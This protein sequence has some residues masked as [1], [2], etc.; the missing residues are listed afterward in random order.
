MRSR[1]RV[2]TFARC[3]LFVLAAAFCSV[4]CFASQPVQRSIAVDGMTRSYV[5][6]IPDGP[7][8]P[9]PVV[10][11]FHGGGGTVEALQNNSSLHEARDARN[12]LI[13]YPVGYR[14][15]FNV[16]G[17]CCGP[18]A[19]QN[20]D[21][22]GF[23]RALLADLSSVAPIDRRRIYSVG[24]SNGGQFS[25]YLACHMSEQ[26]AAIASVAGSM[27]P[28]FDTCRPSRPVPI[29]QWSG[30]A[31]RFDPFEGGRSAI[32]SAPLQPPVMQGIELWR[33][34][35]GTRVT[36]P[37]DVV[38]PGANCTESSGGPGNAAVVLCLVPGL[39][40]QWPG[41]N[42]GPSARMLPQLGPL[43]PALDVNDAIL[44]FFSRYSLP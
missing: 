6:W 28:P 11:A 40:H 31:D 19:R 22:L 42:Q 24:F 8:R 33:R 15:T 26:I 9:L 2:L 27:Q 10:L 12:F 13:V 25:Y 7:R 14:R 41:R 38:G 32:A 36:Q 30:L 1:A 44:G 16:G 43:G 21:D 3:V 17:Y 35:N 29:M 18:A 23:V 34:L 5:V 39:G 4:P 20:I 37:A